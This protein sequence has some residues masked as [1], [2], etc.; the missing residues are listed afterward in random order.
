LAV[1]ITA[2]FNSVQSSKSSLFADINHFN[3]PLKKKKTFNGFKV[4]HL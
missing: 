3:G 2:S 1:S 4:P